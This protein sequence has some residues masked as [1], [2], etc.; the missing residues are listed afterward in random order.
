MLPPH[1]APGRP[2]AQHRRTMRRVGGLL[3]PLAALVF[4][5]C[6]TEPATHVSHDAATLH[7]TGRCHGTESGEAWFAYRQVGATAWTESPHQVYACRGAIPEGVGAARI[8]GLS[9]ATTYE[10][11]LEGQYYGRLVWY[12]SVGTQGGTNYDRF[13]TPAHPTVTPK[14]AA[15]FR[16]SLGVNVH[17]SYYDTV[18]THAGR[19]GD[20]IVDLGLRHVRDGAIYSSVDPAYHE[21]VWGKQDALRDRGLR[22]DFVFTPEWCGDGVGTVRQNLDN[23]AERYPNAVATFEGPN[24]ADKYCTTDWQ[25]RTSSF[26][27]QL[28]AEVREH[29]SAAI[30]SRP[31][32]APSF[33]GNLGAGIADHGRYIDFGNT[34]PYTGC[35]SPS[36]R[37]LHEVIAG[38]QKVNPGEP[39][40]A[41]EVG[42]H[43]ALGYD[44]ASGAQPPCDERTGA[45]YTL[46]TALEHFKAGIARSFFY[47]AIDL[48]PDPGRTEPEWNFGL[49]RNDFSPKPAYT[50]LK[51]LLSAVGSGAPA[52]LEPLTLSVD[53]GPDDLRTLVLQ[54]ADGSYVVALWRLASVWDRH[55]STP[56][57][58]PA[59]RVELSL[60]DASS[61]GAI[62]PVP[63]STETPLSLSNGRVTVELGGDPI[64]LRVLA[65]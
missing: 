36:P 8:R 57:A 53:S 25:N 14:S 62:E 16:D 49:L 18:Y 65:N 45:V 41:T 48:A 13:T 17:S 42:F 64:L 11:R 24:E 2:D 31:I 46:R 15:A 35:A 33:V 21:F 20:A 28:F 23:I 34:H 10:F 27:S 19:I 22:F 3:L 38:A 47:E 52:A 61:V 54:R 30:R 40:F 4:A 56:I 12:D 29:P 9:D 63:S 26:T 1:Q 59:Q 32:V 39:V 55:A 44:P 37:H 5:A 50:A 60:P 43:T 7:G 51:N 6:E 58:V